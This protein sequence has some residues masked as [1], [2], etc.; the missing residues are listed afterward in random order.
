MTQTIAKTLRQPM[1]PKTNN[2]AG[3]CIKILTPVE[4]QWNYEKFRFRSDNG[5]E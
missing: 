1:P 4:H 3:R 2:G 5:S